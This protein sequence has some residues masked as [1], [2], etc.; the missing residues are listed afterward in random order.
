METQQA[1]KSAEEIEKNAKKAKKDA[2]ETVVG[3]VNNKAKELCTAAKKLELF[4][5]QNK[6]T[7]EQKKNLS[8]EISL[9]SAQLGEAVYNVTEAE[10]S[11]Q[12]S[13]G[14]VE[15]AKRYVHAAADVELMHAT[16]AS[17]MSSITSVIDKS[18]EV[19]NVIESVN[20]TMQTAENA[21]KNAG[22]L[23]NE[24]S[25]R[26]EA[27]KSNFTEILKSI[28]V[29]SSEPV[30]VCDTDH[31][32]RITPTFENLKT[33]VPLLRSIK[34]IN[35]EDVNKRVEKYAALIA[36]ASAGADIATSHSR[37]AQENAVN[38]TKFATEADKTA[39]SVLKQALAKQKER[40][41]NA[42]AKLKE[43]NRNATSLR[44]HASSMKT[45]A[46]EHWRRAAAAA[47]SAEDA[48]AQA[49]A[50]EL[51]AEK[52]NKEYQLTTEAV[53][54]TKVEVRH[55]MKSAAVLLRENEEHL[56]KISSSFETALRMSPTERATVLL[57]FAARQLMTAP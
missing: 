13:S 32:K 51:Y 29:V 54:K 36:N 12:K 52:V 30:K 10:K 42:A 50:A 39:R 2:V 7:T 49:V 47:R 8:V 48:A 22:A 5:D 1:V 6:K 34:T 24:E 23:L 35:V 45:Y 38:S 19:V 18:K 33:A 53:R 3:E 9:V 4:S 44:D 40:L 17:C 14:V 20:K 56:N 57:M 43:V 37:E 27:A 25:T 15:G 31:F 26:L 46:T 16:N 21:Q 28:G 41:C 11:C 55:A